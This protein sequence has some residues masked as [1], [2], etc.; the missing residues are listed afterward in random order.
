MNSMSQTPASFQILAFYLLIG[1]SADVRG[2]RLNRVPQ[3][4]YGNLPTANSDAGKGLIDWAPAMVV[5]VASLLSLMAIAVIP[6]D[7]QAVAAFFPPGFEH[8]DAYERVAAADGVVLRTAGFRGVLI[9]RS[10]NPN[11]AARLRAAGAWLV[12]AAPPYASCRA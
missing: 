6:V 7:G 11:F 1:H 2:C 3:L 10:D 9:A 8:G 4:G 12:L 5:A